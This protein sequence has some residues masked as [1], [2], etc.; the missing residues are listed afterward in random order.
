MFYITI[1]NGL[2]KDG[3][4]QRMG[5]AV[6]EFMWLIDKVTK[7]N[8]NG[9]GYV[10]GGKP[11]KLSELA[12]EMRVRE[13]TISEHLSILEKEGYIR[14]TLHSYGVS[15][16]VVKTKKRFGKSV[17]QISIEVS[18]KRKPHSEKRKPLYIDNT[19]DNTISDEVK[20]LNKRVVEIIDAFKNI[21][22]EYSSWYN[23]KTQR[24][25]VLRL[26]KSKDMETIIKVIGILPKT[27][28]I[29]FLP[30]ITTPYKLAMKWS[31]L[32]AGMMK[33]KNEIISKGRGLA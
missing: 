25:A 22:S 9:D 4:R 11:I 23:N 33:K 5:S 21:N 19:V 27:N 15:I 14:K 18:E 13:A 8:E 12:N 28:T 1:S 3:H 2:L 30:V 26:L 24:N 16:V 31:D 32:Q 7:V 10:L 29:P 20:L 6:W 17:N